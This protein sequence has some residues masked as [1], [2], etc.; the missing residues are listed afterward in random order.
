MK[1]K[2]LSFIILTL[3]IITVF[4]GLTYA[5]IM[6]QKESTQLPIT[7]LI[8]EEITSRKN[9]YILPTETMMFTHL[10]FPFKKSVPGSLQPIVVITN[11]ANG[12]V[13]TDPHL[14]V[15][16]YA[17]DETGMNYW[18][19]TWD[20]ACGSHSN[21]SYFETASYVEFTIDINGLC[22]GWNEITVTFKNLDGLT[23]SDL[24][25]VTY[26]PTDNEPP[27]VTITFP[28]DG[29]IITTPYV[30]VTGTATDNVGIT[31]IGS[32]HKWEDGETWTSSTIDPPATYYPFEWTFELQE[33]WNNITIFSTDSAQNYGE[34]SVNIT[35]MPAIPGIAFYQVNY[36]FDDGN[37]LQDS[38]IGQIKIHQKT[39]TS[40]Y[41][42]STGF[43]NVITPLGWVVQNML[44]TSEG[45]GEN[46]PY[47][48]NKFYLRSGAPSNIDVEVLD[49]YITISNTPQPYIEP[50]DYTTFAVGDLT[51]YIEGEYFIPSIPPIIE[52]PCTPTDFCLQDL[53]DHP[54]VQA[55]CNQCAPCAV[56]NSLQYLENT[57]PDKISIP[58]DNEPGEDGDDTLPGQLDEA[59]DRDVTSR[60]DGDGVWPLHG[61]LK[62]LDDNNLGQHIK[63][64]YQG[65]V[66]PAADADGHTVGNATAVNKG[67]KV[68]FQWIFDEICAGE[69]VE[70]IIEYPNGAT[71]A[72]ELT[73]AGYLCGR[74]FILHISDQ[75]QN[76]DDPDDEEGCDSE[77]FEWLDDDGNGTVEVVSGSSGAGTKI[78]QVYSQSP[79]DPPI[80][81][82]TPSGPTNVKPDEEQTYT[83]NIPSDPDGDE[84]TRYEWDFDG[85]G[86]VDEV[87]STPTVT[88]A[89]SEKGTYEMSVRV[90]DEYGAVSEW[91]DPLEVSVPRNKNI[92]L[93][94]WLFSQFSQK[95][96]RF[97][98]PSGILP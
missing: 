48:T 53:E 14:T 52:F 36:K 91:S 55:A 18:E 33:G 31:S 26:V 65:H 86:K 64:K 5:R 78:I 84:I 29:A 83:T 74:P 34:D 38:Y 76:D 10:L 70:A 15:E 49:A 8:S 22:P 98:S 30:I 59:M 43:L 46:I 7:P 80:K 39:L 2:F 20:S 27:V 69:D 3:L 87:T 50:G 92:F 16:G 44:I 90:R 11:P 63:T 54:N 4:N 67:E 32:H 6:E 79:N 61:K 25:N 85:D 94:H 41:G 81:P 71:H 68:S 75:E 35:Y 93:I 56:A 77:Q 40:F 37:E 58:H 66:D 21:S 28:S 60:S 12:A 19:W 57:Y 51:A 72:I 45:I 95:H 47:I 96:F 62:Y 17:A 73:G 88:H 82:V 23:G 89:W 97:F 1:K 42:I 9:Q 24:I 13:L